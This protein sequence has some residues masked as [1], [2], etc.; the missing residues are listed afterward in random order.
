MQDCP[1][2]PLTDPDTSRLMLIVVGAHLDAELNDRPLAYRLRERVLEML[3]EG[4]SRGL[5]PIVCC[6]VWYLN[7]ESLKLRPTISIGG[8]EINAA[9][10]WLAHRL[11]QA[12]VVEEAFRLHLDPE[13]IDLRACLWGANVGATAS[14]VDLLAERYLA[15]YLEA[16]ACLKD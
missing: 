12:F 13:L 16:A 1:A 15:D 4:D 11:P 3:D 7:D 8:P 2:Q 14:G 6:D 9:T 10:A 5:I